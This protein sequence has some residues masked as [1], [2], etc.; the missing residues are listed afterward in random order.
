[1]RIEFDD[2][3]SL[4]ADLVSRPSVN[5][6][7]REH[8]AT[9]PVER[10]SL[11]R[12]AEVFKP[13][14][15]EMAWQT[16]SPIHESLLITVP[17]RRRDRITLLESHVDTVPADDWGPAAFQPRR[18]GSLLYG[19][20]ACDDK[21]P[22][23]AMILAVCDILESGASPPTDL[24]LMAA[25]D[26]EYAQ[27]GIKTYVGTNPRVVRGVFGEPTSLIPVL[28]HKGTVRWDVIV[29]GR[30]V[31][32][33]QPELGCDAIRG[34]VQVLDW[35]DERQTV[36]RAGVRSELLTG[37][38]I[39]VTMIRGGRTRN[40]VADECSL[41]VDFR[42]TPG[43]D[44]AEAR[45]ELNQYLLDRA[46]AA[47]AAWKLSFGEPQITTPPLAT[48]PD[49]A[50]SR[51]VLDICRRELN[52]PDLRF[53]GAPYGTDAAWVSDRCPAIVLGPGSID[54][55][56]SVVEHVD[57]NEV[58]TC[59]RMYRDIVLSEYHDE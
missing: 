23:T 7:G 15:V 22:L 21:G 31:H 1:M 24:V 6:M 17:G 29:H 59:S 35:L 34:A 37:P 53:L 4:L 41:A 8:A 5:P 10:Q 49:A 16:C 40:A 27:T 20:G 11:L 55:A 52:R 51:Q 56:H 57:I 18:E 42:V 26:E 46:A 3:A 48:A 14:G 58:V 44:P 39:V 19:R 38:S 12:I 30:S 43:M 54:V 32:S 33:S 36:L 13:Y 28:Q 45:R 47:G 9:E 2:A 50:F 25:G